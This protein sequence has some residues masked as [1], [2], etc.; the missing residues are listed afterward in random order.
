MTE[1][2]LRKLFSSNVREYRNRL[3]WSQVALAKKTGVSVN[4]LNDIE[5]GRK[6]ISPATLVK[7]ANALNVEAHELLKPPDSFP[8]NLNSIVK[9]YTENIHAA[10]DE[11][12]LAFMQRGT[13][14]LSDLG[15]GL[16]T[17]ETR[18]KK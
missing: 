10:V 14:V 15:A 8:D 7:L 17:E 3:K 9:K 5:L 13:S 2:E 4:F 12:R 11:A 18:R 6:W 16:Q 1:K